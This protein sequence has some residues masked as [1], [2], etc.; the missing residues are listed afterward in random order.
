MKN[1]AFVREVQFDSDE[2]EDVYHIKTDD[3]GNT[4]SLWWVDREIIL[5]R[6]QLR[7]LSCAIELAIGS[8]SSRGPIE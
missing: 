7:L 2:D 5:T 8:N 1:A 4:Y 3:K 6:K